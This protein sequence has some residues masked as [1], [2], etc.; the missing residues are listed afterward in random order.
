M[1][2]LT[3]P[4]NEAKAGIALVDHARPEDAEAILTVKREAW[5]SSYPDKK[6]G[7]TVE[8]IRKKFTDEELAEGIKNWQSALASEKP[9]GDRW[10][11][12]ARVGGKVLGAA[13]PFIDS[14][15][16]RWLGMM[17]VSP[18]A[19][20]KG[21]G[22]S[23]LRAAIEWHA[24]NDIYLNVVSYNQNAIDFYKHFGFQETGVTHKGGFYPNGT[25]DLPEIE[26]VLKV[27]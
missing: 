25:K 12:V 10:T 26:M 22:G 2:E 20:H 11:Y 7:V 15:G 21:I 24:H 14:D 13:S 1:S 16:K 18:D 4:K 8:D 23:L 5:L 6:Q 17:Y 19:Q 9:D 27:N 3:Q